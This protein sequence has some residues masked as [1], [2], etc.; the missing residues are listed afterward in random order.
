M[1]NEQA[2]VYAGTRD[3]KWLAD[4]PRAELH[5]LGVQGMLFQPE[6]ATQTVL[7]YRVD[8]KVVVVMGTVDVG[9]YIQG[10]AKGNIDVTIQ[11]GPVGSLNPYNL[12]IGEKLEE[13][14]CPPIDTQLMRHLQEEGITAPVVWWGND[15]KQS[16]ARLGSDNEEPIDEFIRLEY[17]PGPRGTT[18]VIDFEIPPQEELSDDDPD[19]LRIILGGGRLKYLPR[20]QGPKQTPIKDRIVDPKLKKMFEEIDKAFGKKK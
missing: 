17:D 16:S 1:H 12:G 15:G 14:V 13:I 11:Q 5:C 18:P 7:L 20:Q 6:K 4:V 10:L 2:M 19:G 9:S 8:K 3:T